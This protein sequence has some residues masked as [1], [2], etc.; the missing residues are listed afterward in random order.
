M[1]FPGLQC[2]ESARNAGDLSLIPGSGRSPKGNGYPLQ[3]S[4]LENSMDRGVWK[5]T[6]H[7]VTESDTTEQL[8]HTLVSQRDPTFH[9][10]RY[11]NREDKEATSEA[12]PRVS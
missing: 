4:C 2:K 1:G 5:A 12:K 9:L 8:T 11:W 7:G 10:T 3:Y 6:A